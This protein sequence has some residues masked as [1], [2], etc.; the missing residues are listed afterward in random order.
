MTEMEVI[1][2]SDLK[3]VVKLINERLAQGWK[4]S[5]QMVVTPYISAEAVQNFQPSGRFQYLQSIYRTKKTK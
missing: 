4:I 2:G 5:G 1:Y 3:A